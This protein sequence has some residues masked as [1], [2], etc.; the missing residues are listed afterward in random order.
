LY[1]SISKKDAHTSALMGADT[2]KLCEMQGFPPRLDNKN[3]SRVEANIQ[4]FKAEFVIARLFNL[5]LPTINILSDGGIDLWHGNTS[6]DVKFTNKEEG[7]LVFDTLDKFRAD[8]AILVGA[9]SNPNVFKVNGWSDKKYFSL[10]AQAC[11]FG[12]GPRLK[13]EVHETKPIETLWR[14]FMIEK[15]GNLNDH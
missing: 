13:L 11:D 15:F 2:V 3:Q 8:V 10:N 1:L 7:P 12:Y 6:I 14:C 5:D 4:G 9:T